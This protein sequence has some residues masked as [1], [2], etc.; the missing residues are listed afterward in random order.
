MVSSWVIFISW[1]ETIVINIVNRIIPRENIQVRMS[2][3]KCNAL[4]L[5]P[6]FG[7]GVVLARADMVEPCEGDILVPIRAVP[8]KRLSCFIPIALAEFTI[9]PSVR[10]P[11]LRE[12]NHARVR[13]PLRAGGTLR[14]GSSIALVFVNCVPAIGIRVFVKWQRLYYTAPIRGVWGRV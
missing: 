5:Q 11:T 8:Q 2:I 14:R 9:A 7:A 3:E 1:S 13:F 12:G 4:P 6:S 10:F